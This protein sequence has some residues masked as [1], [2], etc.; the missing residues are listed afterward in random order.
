[1]DNKK[2]TPR[3]PVVAV[4]GHI[5]HGKSTLL[6]YIRETNTTQKEA[7]G[8]TQ[9]ISAYVAECNVG[10]E[11]KKITFLDTPGHEA[12]SSIRRRSTL[13][14][15][16]A[17]LVVS[18]EDGVKP[19]TSEALQC[20][21]EDCI[22]FI[23]ALNKIDRAGVNI[24]KAKQNLAEH[25]ILVEG[26]GGDIPLVPISAKTGQG[27][28]DLLE[29]I[30][31]QSDLEELR[32]DPSAPAEGF[33]IES[34]LNPK[35][36]ISAVLIIKNG[37]LKVG[38]F[39]AAY[40]ACAPVRMIE[41]YEGKSI[42]TA[43]FSEPVRIVG[44]S[45]LPRPGSKFKTFP[46]KEEAVAFALQKPEGEEEKEKLACAE[47]FWEVVVKAD[48]AGSLDAVEQELAKMNT[49]KIAV[50][51][52]SKGIGAIT[53]KDVKAAMVK[54]CAVLGFNVDIDKNAEALAIRENIEVKTYNIIYDLIDF[55][56][57]KIKE[58]APEE[59]VE[60]ITGSA[61]ILKTFSQNKDKQVVGGRAEEGEIKMGNAAKIFRR[62]AE[63]GSGKVKE[64]QIQKVKTD[65]V[66]GGQE[67]GL[68]IESKIE[69]VPGD[70]IK[71][72]SFTKK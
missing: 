37:T 28:P 60:T 55:A 20:I 72:S 3:P 29:M 27:V 53:E 44:W 49:G 46:K 22:P 10:G 6:D 40:G 62:D 51:I 36:G 63:I 14:A 23:V 19:Q 8:I 33:V 69:I 61:K 56:A 42:K 50:K 5:D 64:L 2:L 16:I 38:D 67:F 11:N 13:A 9:H 70:V 26:W 68:M 48:T 66:K 17:V 45:D 65:S 52:I 12:F 25:E 31:L 7:G 71:I 18:A 39:V 15:D 34:N 54:K 21:K 30:I 41:N 4:M 47:N 59:I 57:D 1:M 58:N 43:S 32:G 24:D 35:Q